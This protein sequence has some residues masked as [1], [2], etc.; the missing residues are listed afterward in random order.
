ML[1]FIPIPQNPIPPMNAF[2]SSDRELLDV[3]GTAQGGL[4]QT[5]LD[6]MRIRSNMCI[7]QI[8]GPIPP[9]FGRGGAP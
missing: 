5:V 1:D 8:N 2:L 7:R 9:F 3:V 6:L 4:A